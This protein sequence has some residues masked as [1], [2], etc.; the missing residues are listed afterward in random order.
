MADEGLATTAKPQDQQDVNQVQ[1]EATDVAEGREK[2]DSFSNLIAD[3][4]K[5]NWTSSY[6]SSPDGGQKG[7][8]GKERESDDDS[9]APLVPGRPVANLRLW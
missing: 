4:E 2:E 5:Y 6:E 7:Q 9:D 1:T 3:A 8:N